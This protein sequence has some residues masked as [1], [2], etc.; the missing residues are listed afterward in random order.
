MR[1]E[2]G[3]SGEDGWCERMGLLASATPVK[4]AANLEHARK[5]T[6]KDVGE[7]CGSAKNRVAIRQRN[8]GVSQGLGVKN[9]ESFKDAN[10]KGNARKRVVRQRAMLFL[11]LECVKGAG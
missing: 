9:V 8:P 6:L 4:K 1:E 7:R 3:R 5:A 2:R 10:Q 11:L